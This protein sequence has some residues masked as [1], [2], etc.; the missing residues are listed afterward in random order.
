[1]SIQASNNNRA[2]T[3][4]DVFRDGVKEWGLPSCMRGDHGTENIQVAA[5]MNYYRGP[6]RGSYLWGRYEFQLPTPHSTLTHPG[7]EVCIIPELSVF[8]WMSRFSLSQNGR[9]FSLSLSFSM[10]SVLIMP[11]IFGFSSTYFSLES[12]M[13]FN[14]S[15][16]H[17][18]I[19]LY[20]EMDK[21]Y[22]HLLSALNGTCRYMVYEEI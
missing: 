1:M 3:V 2:L 18:T 22:R 6:Q 9:I 15:S 10:A 8:G 21:E 7:L 13:S 16:R 12:M 11:A 19:I 17:G 14:A 5:Y 20:S 4:L